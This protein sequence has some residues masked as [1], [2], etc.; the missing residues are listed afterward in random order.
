MN[1]RLARDS[2]RF[3]ISKEELPLLLAGE[4]LEETI[5]LAD[6]VVVRVT[7]E[8][9]DLPEEKPSRLLSLKSCSVNGG[10]SITLLLSPA[11]LR[12]LSEKHESRNGVEALVRGEN[13]REILLT[14]EV[15]QARPKRKSPISVQLS[16]S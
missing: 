13:G 10:I 15:D 16:T 1:L 7:I 14:L 8:A 4:R 3:R 12:E 6:G 2:L 11:A 5:P 9:E